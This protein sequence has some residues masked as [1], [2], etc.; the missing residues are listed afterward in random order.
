METIIFTLIAYGACN[1]MIFG[2]IFEGWRNFLKMFGT[3]GYSLHKLFTC[4]MCLATWWGFLSTFVMIKLNYGHLTPCGSI[5]VN[6]EPL[7]IFFNGL[8]TSGSVWLIHNLEEM[9]ERI[10][11]NQ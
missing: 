6:N 7:M 9:F 11:N 5:G 2:S 4:F 8:F 1:N 3:G 10:G